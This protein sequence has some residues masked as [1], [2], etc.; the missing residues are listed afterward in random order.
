M[1]D[2]QVGDTAMLECGRCRAIWIDA[3][4]FEHIVTNQE[5]QSAVL[6]H[7]PAPPSVRTGAPVQYRKCVACGTMMNR[8][9][10]GRLSGTIVDVCRGHGTFLDAGELH[11]L[12][13]FIQSG[14]LDRARQRQIEEL[15]EQEQRARMAQQLYDRATDGVKMQP[16]MGFD[17]LSLLDHLRRK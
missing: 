6:H 17:L 1:S 4:S 5:S 13:R 15:K 8:L 14:G 16:T 2:V 10:F 9:N 11:A 7:W 12:V 3:A